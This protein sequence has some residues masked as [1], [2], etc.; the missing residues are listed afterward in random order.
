VTGRVNFWRGL[1]PLATKKDLLEGGSGQ[2]QSK[3]QC[4]FCIVE[5]KTPIDTK[6]GKVGGFKGKRWC[7][8][9]PS[10]KGRGTYR[11]VKRPLLLVETGKTP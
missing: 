2:T 11:R 9:R 3:S 5:K 1:I 6:E 8:E 10:G 4:H 7:G